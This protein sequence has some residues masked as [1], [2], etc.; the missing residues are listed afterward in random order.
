MTNFHY[1][2]LFQLKINKQ[3]KYLFKFAW[4]FLYPFN[5]STNHTKYSGKFDQKLVIPQS[6]GNF[7]ADK[8][9]DF[10]QK[11]AIFNKNCSGF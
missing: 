3:T 9:R 2:T 11:C 5:L 8:V 1:F 7:S 4:K 10:A 6:F